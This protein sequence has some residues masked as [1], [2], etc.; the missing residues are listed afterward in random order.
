MSTFLHHLLS[1]LATLASLGLIAIVVS[2]IRT[3]HL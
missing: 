3:L 1:L 2:G